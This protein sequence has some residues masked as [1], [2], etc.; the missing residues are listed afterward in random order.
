MSRRRSLWHVFRMPIAIGLVSFA[1]LVWALLIEG[2]ADRF[3]SAAAGCG[4]GA[5]IWALLK[6]R[7]AGNAPADPSR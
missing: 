3:A 1:G 5:L 2:P 7:P 6:R 4:L